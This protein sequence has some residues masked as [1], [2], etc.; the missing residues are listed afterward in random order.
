MT[1]FYRAAARDG[2]V[3]FAATLR[4]AF[5]LGFAGSPAGLANSYG[6]TA[7]R[8]VDGMAFSTATTY[9]RHST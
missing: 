7:R 4:A 6:N 3:C 8:T 2:G 5:G 1:F 9:N